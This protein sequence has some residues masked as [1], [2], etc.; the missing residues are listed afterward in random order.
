MDGLLSCKQ[1][2]PEV[3]LPLCHVIRCQNASR[4][5][6][7]H[8]LTLRA[9]T[10]CYLSKSLQSD[11]VLHDVP[12]GFKKKT[13][14]PR[15]LVA[16]VQ[17]AWRWVR[18]KPWLKASRSSTR[19]EDLLLA[20]NHGF[21]DADKKPLVQCNRLQLSHNN[22][23][24]AFCARKNVHEMASHEA[25]TTTILLVPNTHKG[26]LTSIRPKLDIRGP[27]EISIVDP[28]LGHLL[29]RQVLIV[30]LKGC[31][32]I[33]H[34]QP[35]YSANI[36]AVCEV[37]V[38]ADSRMASKDTMAAISAAPLEAM[39]Q[40]I[41]EQFPDSTACFSLGGSAPVHFH[42]FADGA[43]AGRSD[44]IGCRSRPTN[45]WVTMK[46]LGHRIN[47]IHLWMVNENNSA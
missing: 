17:P 45:G 15:H 28:A 7:K 41:H 35:I 24:I 1:M 16:Q 8:R 6:L 18:Y 25:G 9:S 30:C 22:G 36:D 11:C 29:K 33:E 20:P 19:R 34:P 38:E 46:Y 37:V 39:K 43:R 5:M 13:C 23:G 4:T 12:L 27:V 3:F 32:S 42:C 40:R 47:W 44:P 2:D 26:S 31:A 21:V 14:P 10:S